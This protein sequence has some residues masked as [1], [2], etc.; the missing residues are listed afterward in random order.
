MRLALF[1]LPVF[2]LPG[3]R[4]RLSIFEPRYNRLVSESVS[5]KKGFGLCLPS[6]SNSVYEIGTRVQIFDFGQN[7]NGLLTIDV[8]GL[9]RF[10]F[11]KVSTD[12]DGLM[13]AEVTRIEGWQ[14]TEMS[15][16]YDF[17]L[18]PLKDAL[19]SH[20]LYLEKINNHLFDDLSWVCQRWLEILP[21]PTQ[22]KYWLAKQTNIE[23]VVDFIRQNIK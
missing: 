23:P 7:E 15:A 18:A 6:D 17:I 10:T 1:P 5:T 13:H 2:L 20:P 16:K 3:G 22:K 4:T 12:S 14:T 21:I 9:D 8:K 11:Q 19:I